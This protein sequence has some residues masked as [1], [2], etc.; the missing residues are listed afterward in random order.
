MTVVLPHEVERLGPDVQSWVEQ[1]LLRDL[2]HYGVVQA[3]LRFDWSQALQEG[4]YTE[5]RGRMLESLSEVIVRTADDCI[6]AEGWMDFVYTADGKD[7]EPRLFWLFLSLVADGKLTRVKEDAF[8]P[9][10]LWES[11]SDAEKRFVAATGSK[12]VDRDLKVRAWM[13][14]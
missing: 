3:N 13:R 2:Q 5:F 10:H 1:Q 11:L 14:R 9:G 12:W 8:L 6:L 7:S 4:H